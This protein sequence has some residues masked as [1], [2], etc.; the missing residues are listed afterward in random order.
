MKQ[1][2][3]FDAPSQKVSTFF[4]NFRL[5]ASSA[6][7]R[8]SIDQSTMSMD[9]PE[10]VFDGAVPVA[11]TEGAGASLAGGAAMASQKFTI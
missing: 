8:L 4:V 6:P 1:L 10:M 9:A 11:S 3:P 5:T 7:N 2:F